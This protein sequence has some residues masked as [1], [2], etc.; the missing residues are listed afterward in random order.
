MSDQ[1]VL[2]DYDRI[3]ARIEA[4]ELAAGVPAGSWR[5]TDAKTWLAA[6]QFGL[7]RNVALAEREERE[8]V[9]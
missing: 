1:L 5:T 3:A 2:L 9:S 7:R 4:R 8:R 6:I